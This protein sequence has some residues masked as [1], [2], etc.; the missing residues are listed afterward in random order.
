MSLLTAQNGTRNLCVFLRQAT[1]K[2]SLRAAL[3]AEVLRLDNIIFHPAILKL[4][5]GS[6]CAQGNLVQLVLTVDNH[7]A[8][9]AQVHQHLCQRLHQIFIINTKQLQLRAGGIRQ[10]SEDVEN[11]ADAQL[12]ADW[13]NI[14]H[15]G[16]ILLCEEEAHAHLLQQLHAFFRLQ[17][18][19]YAQRLQ[20]IGSAAFGGSSAIAMLGNLHAAG[21]S[22]QS[23]GRGDI[24]AIRSVA[25]RTNDFKNVHAG[26]ALQSVVTHRSGAAGD[27]LCR[28]SRRALS[29][30]RCQK[31]SVLRS[32]CCTAHDFTDYGVSLSIC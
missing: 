8:L 26:F 20:T 2:V 30:Q 9:Y 13:A 14:F 24:E 23:R 15:R 6:R 21:R 4:A 17:L 5:D 27:F 11:C 29:R 32:T 31:C 3:H 1:D 22:H 18:N 25:A 12:L 19:I 10:R 16:V 7:A 28:F